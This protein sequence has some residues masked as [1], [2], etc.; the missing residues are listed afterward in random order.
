MHNYK[1]Y[2][3][4]IFIVLIPAIQHG[5]HRDTSPVGEAAHETFAW[6]LPFVLAAALAR[7]QAQSSHP[8]G[9]YGLRKTWI[10]AD[11]TSFAIGHRDYENYTVSPDIFPIVLAKIQGLSDTVLGMLTFLIVCSTGHTTE[12]V[13]ESIREEGVRESIRDNHRS[14]TDMIFQR[15]N[16]TLL[17]T[18]EFHNPS[19]DFRLVFTIGLY[20]IRRFRLLIPYRSLYSNNMGTLALEGKVI[21]DGELYTWATARTEEALFSAL[22]RHSAWSEAATPL[23]SDSDQEATIPDSDDYESS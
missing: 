19:T 3:V 10:A 23:D 13:R 22:H 6:N 8:K 12:A 2:K 7:Y 20:N 15:E 14:D 16:L 11:G 21:S 18:T 17:K 5:A 1:N 9:P 4:L